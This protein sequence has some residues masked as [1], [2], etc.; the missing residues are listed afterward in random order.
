MTQNYNARLPNSPPVVADFNV[1]IYEDG[2][3]DLPRDSDNPEIY[4]GG[5]V[6]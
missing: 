1:T 4:S 2:F 6:W 5:M 3:L